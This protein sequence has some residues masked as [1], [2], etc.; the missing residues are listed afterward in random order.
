MSL[1]SLRFNLLLLAGACAVAGCETIADRAQ[2]AQR[3]LANYTNECGRA[4]VGSVSNRLDLKRFQLSD[5]V[6]F[7]AT[8]RPDLESSRLAVS[9]AV[10]SL[11]TVTT[12]RRLQADLSAGYSQAT[13]NSGPNREHFSWHQNR[14]SFS[15]DISFDLLLY[16][17]GRLDARER[18]AREDLVAAKRSYEDAELAV[19]HEVC[20]AY[21]TLRCN[22]A[23]LEVARTNEVMHAEHLKQSE[24]LFSVGEAKKLDVLKAR[25]DLSDAKLATINASNDVV[26]AGAEFLR[27]LGLDQDRARREEVLPVAAD[28][29]AETTNVLPVSV[30]TAADALAI[31]RTNSPSLAGLRAQLR[32]AMADVDLAVAN[33]L[34]NISV[35]SA[36]NFTDPAWNWSWGFKA[37]QYLMDGFRRE[38]AVESAM[39]AME[40]ARTEVEAAEQTLSCELAVAAA[41]RDNARQSL[42]TARVEVEQA[43]ENYENVMMQYRV[44]DASRLDFTDAVGTLANALGVRV[45]AF[46][47]AEV[48]ESKLVRLTGCDPWRRTPPAKPVPASASSLSIKDLRK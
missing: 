3:K 36:F 35:S 16:D 25:V 44:G 7:A 14:G 31:S 2:A 10:L 6:A 4:A 37:T 45:K 33:M 26:T 5:Y 27:A 19:F 8:N 23:L 32:A 30:Y 28:C 47:A 15:G 39:V 46:Y 11:L 48:A 42:A 24:Q 38:L 40:A 18:A 22:D 34:P 9:N 17:F 43:R 20:Q 13:L 1:F 41:S 21:F 12:D 29:L